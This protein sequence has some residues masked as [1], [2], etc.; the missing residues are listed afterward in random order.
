MKRVTTSYGVLEGMEQKDYTLFLGVPYAAPPVGELRWRAPQKPQP[1]EGVRMANRFPNRS[2][3]ETGRPMEFYDREFYDVPERM[4]QVSEDSLYL[5]IWTPANTAQ[6]RLPVAV[7][8]HGGAFMG[9]F[10]HEKE[11][12]G[13][14]LCRK[15]VLLVTINYRLG[16]MGFLAHP[17]LSAE[18]PHGVS[19]NY[20]ILDQIQALTWVRENIA[21]FGGDPENITIFGQSAGCMSVQ[22]LTSSPLT[23]GLFAR[24]ILQSGLGLSSDRPLTMAEQQGVDIANNAGVS[25][26]EELRALP[27]AE[28][29]KASGPVMEAYRGLIFTPVTDGYVL[30]AGV[31]QLQ[32]KGRV[33]DIPY[34]LGSTMQ[35]IATDSE[36]LKRGDRGL[37]YNGC[38]SWC[39]MLLEQQRQPA[40]RYYFTRQLP[41]DDSG[42]FHSSELWYTFG[43]YGSCW[44]PMTQADAELSERMV[45]YWTNFMKYSDPN[46]AG[47]P[48]WKPWRTSEDTLTL[49][50]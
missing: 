32:R 12:D 31:E 37:I 49:D 38:E 17:W 21:A 23:R 47:L 35:D 45:S 26:L 22:T 7:W 1:W 10:G 15:G 33:H 9:G 20:G 16:V 27:F 29:M 11:F 2:M 13:Q 28:L 4:T 39:R 6:D 40:Y 19:G 34:L 30:E 3:Q 41:G 5:N 46:G 25:S 43:T 18:D 42:A 36:A 48:E 8:I 14:A 24:A 44:R 50:I